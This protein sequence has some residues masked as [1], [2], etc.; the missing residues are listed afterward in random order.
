MKSK[1]IEQII[2]LAHKQQTEL[3]NTKRLISKI[4]YLIDA[5][6]TNVTNNADLDLVDYF[7]P[8]S[9]MYQT[10][11]NKEKNIHDTIQSY[12][13]QLIEIKKAGID[14]NTQNIIEQFFQQYPEAETI[15]KTE[16][17]LSDVRQFTKERMSIDETVL[18]T[19]IDITGN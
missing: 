19:D 11:I 3:A 9:K 6:L 17:Q 18:D 5:I 10:V 8:L 15:F 4:E 13:K 16:G 1:L 12:L 14:E 2:E 7:E